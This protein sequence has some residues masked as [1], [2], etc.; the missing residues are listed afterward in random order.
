MLIQIIK[1]KLVCKRIQ[2]ERGRDK[3][4]ERRGGE[5]GEGK[6]RKGKGRGR[7]A[8]QSK[9]QAQFPQTVLYCIANFIH[10]CV[11]L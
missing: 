4:R 7:D 10:A 6:G 11:R 9:G 8:E 2:Y 5:E 1:K 3:L